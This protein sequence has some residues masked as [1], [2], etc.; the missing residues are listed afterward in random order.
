[1][2]SSERHQLKQDQF[3]VATQE[4]LDWASEHRQLIVYGTIIVV[5]L[6]VILAGGFYYLQG[7]EQ[8]ASILLGDALE[9]Y[10]APLRPAGTPETPGTISFTSSADRDKAAAPKFVAVSEKYSHTDAGSMAQYFLGLISEDQ[11]DN[12]KAEGY[13]KEV[14]DK[15]NTDT[16]ALAKMALADLYH[17]T[18]RDQDAINIYKELVN[19]PTNTVTK[20]TAQVHLAELYETKDR[21]QA[22]LIYEEI[23]KENA[24]DQVATGLANTRLQTLGK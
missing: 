12:S 1:L 24:T 8:K 14:A 22:R 15:G 4:T 2:R 20:T 19:K 13:L 18:N 21:A 16:A 23:L 3:A 6:V 17:N 7:R 10:S 9:T 11:G 5:A